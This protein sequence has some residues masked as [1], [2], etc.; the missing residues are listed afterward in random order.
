[1]SNSP[2]GSTGVVFGPM[3]ESGMVAQDI[4]ENASAD[5]AKYRVNLLMKLSSVQSCRCFEYIHKPSVSVLR[6]LI[7]VNSNTPFFAKLAVVRNESSD[8]LYL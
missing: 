3:I 8:A 6:M 4:N 1:M 5:I 2:V 7:Q